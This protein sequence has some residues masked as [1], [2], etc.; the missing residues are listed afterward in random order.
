MADYMHEHNI[1]PPLIRFTVMLN[2]LYEEAG[3][4]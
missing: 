1:A 2:R 4:A 3:V